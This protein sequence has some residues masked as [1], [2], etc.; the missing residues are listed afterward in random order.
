MSQG[1]IDL[2]YLKEFM[3][4]KNISEVKLAQLIGVD[5]T[6]VYRVFRGDRNPGAKFISGLIKSNLDLDMGKIFLN[7]LLPAGN[8]GNKK[9]TETA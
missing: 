4:D 2:E 7:N 6:T 5:Y 1:L 3:D 8:G 9:R